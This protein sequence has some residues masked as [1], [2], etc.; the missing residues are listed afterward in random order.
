MQTP[1]LAL[2]HCGLFVCAMV[3]FFF[4]C[5]KFKLEDFWLEVWHLN[6]VMTLIQKA[7]CPGPLSIQFLAHGM[8]WR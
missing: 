5:H 2:L 3:L 1:S 7:A 4:Y 8:R 6:Q